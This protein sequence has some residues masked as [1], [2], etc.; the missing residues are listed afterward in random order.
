MAKDQA[1]MDI[2]DLMRRTQ[3]LLQPTGTVAPGFEQ[4]T[5]MQQGMVSQTE[6]FARHW[7]ERRQEAVE[8]GLKVL[9]EISKTNGADP[10]GSMQAI[11]D[12]QRGSLDRVTADLQ[13]WTTLCMHAA[14]LAATTSAETPSQDAADQSPK[15]EKRTTTT[16]GRTAST[17]SKS[18]HATPV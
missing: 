12:W 15:A 9:Q 2:M 17:D 10:A 14:T 16:K 8:S 5:K 11:T 4:I 18:H 6:V 13:E 1:Q 7:F 3:A